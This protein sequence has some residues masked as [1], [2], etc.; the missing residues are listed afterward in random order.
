MREAIKV[1]LVTMFEPSDKPGEL[2]QLKRHF[3]LEQV[4]YATT[5]RAGFAPGELHR[6]GSIL[7][8]V[9]GVGTGNTAV[10][11]TTLGWSGVYDVSEAY[12]VVCG[13]AGGDPEAVTLGSVTV[14]DWIVDTDLAYEFSSKEVDESWLT[15]VIPL[16]AREP[17]GPGAQDDEE[18]GNRS[19]Q[20]FQLNEALVDWAFGLTRCLQLLDEEGIQK[21]R[22][23]FKGFPN[24]LNPPIVHKGTTQSGARFLHGD[25]M[26]QWARLWVQRWTGGKSTLHTSGMEDTGTL[27]ALKVLAANQRANDQRV[28]IIRS[29]SNMMMPPPRVDPVRYLTGDPGQ[30]VDFPGFAPALENGCRVT[31][32]IVDEILAGKAPI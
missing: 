19:Y 14:S 9:A 7:A 2:S 8:V 20:V 23:R 10:S 24:A 3:G 11:I 27:L 18:F 15:G 5:V 30:A 21:A 22:S 31:A 12:W 13:I 25:T 16:G 4:D 28:L 6:K 32:K 29:C 1:V 26:V 17:F